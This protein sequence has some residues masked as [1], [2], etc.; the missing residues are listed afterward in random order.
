MEKV[1]D[2]KLKYQTQNDSI[3]NPNPLTGCSIVQNINKSWHVHVQL[4]KKSKH[5]V[6]DQ[7]SWE[8]DAF[9]KEYWIDYS[10]IQK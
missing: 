6:V 4:G 1:E 9:T 8:M 2:V 7:I 10:K 5:A 3:W